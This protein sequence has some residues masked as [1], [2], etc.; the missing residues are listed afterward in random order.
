[1]RR[2]A[3]IPC[4]D[5][6]G[7]SVDARFIDWLFEQRLRPIELRMILGV[8]R[9]ER[10]GAD[11]PLQKEIADYTNT[12]EADVSRW[13]KRLTKRGLMRREKATKLM[14]PSMFSRSLTKKAEPQPAKTRQPR[15]GTESAIGCW[16]R[17]LVRHSD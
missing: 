7:C 13:L 9:F 10:F 16:L 15:S 6:L 17:R 8:K 2:A 14:I 12:N 3:L 4:T 5:W 11:F 1:M